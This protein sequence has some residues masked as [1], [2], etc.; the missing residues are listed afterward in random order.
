MAGR[1]ISAPR[2]K[3]ASSRA[4]C[5]VCKRQ[6]GLEAQRSSC[7]LH[8]LDSACLILEQPWLLFSHWGSRVV[9]LVS[10]PCLSVSLSVCLSVCPPLP[11][12]PRVIPQPMQIPWRCT[13]GGGYGAPPSTG[14]G[15][16]VGGAQDPAA[17]RQQAASLR[18]S[19][20]EY[21]SLQLSS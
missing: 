21:R 12:P 10:S 4:I 15:G 7:W 2:H 20:Q 1:S 13:G 18:G 11:P 8:M 6:V 9:P 14:D 17:D 16:D 3:S 19:V 5:S